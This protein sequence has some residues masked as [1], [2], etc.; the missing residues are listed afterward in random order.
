VASR[1]PGRALV[2]LAI[3]SSL[4]LVVVA[5]TRSRE[6]VEIAD[7]RAATIPQQARDGYATSERC[8]AC[9]PSQYH[10]WH[11]SFH[12][13]MTTYATPATVKGD[14]REQ[15]LVDDLYDVRLFRRGDDFFADMVDPM[16]QFVV[17]HGGQP[18]G[19]PPRVERRI[20]MVTGSHHMQVYWVPAGTGNRQL[21]MPFTYLLEDQRWVS[22]GA[23]FLHPPDQHQPEQ[24]W[25]SGCIT[26]HTTGGQPRITSDGRTADSRVGEMGIACEACHGPGEAHI[27][28]NH[29]PLRRYW[30]HLRGG[31][32]VSTFRIE[33]DWHRGMTR[34]DV[35]DQRGQLALRTQSAEMRRLGFEGADQV[36]RCVYDA[37]TECENAFSLVES[38]R[39]HVRKRIETDADEGRIGFLRGS[40]LLDERSPEHDDRGTIEAARVYRW[41]C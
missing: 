20:S 12:R 11:Q 5:V 28:A 35:V 30:L 36:G 38:R 40:E 25:N 34:V 29:N 10:S 26:C 17:D 32:D 23:V 16:W 2:A 31:A 13:T 41:W 14:F 37:P 33:D 7:A 3:V 1:R 21:T 18:D 9:H 15:R 27:A 22:R 39:H 6:H 4:P 8:D 19:P 24:E